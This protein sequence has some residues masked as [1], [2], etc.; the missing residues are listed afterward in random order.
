MDFCL[1]IADAAHKHGAHYAT[2]AGSGRAGHEGGKKNIIKRKTNCLGSAFWLMSND[3]KRSCWKQTR[4]FVSQH[5]TAP[6]TASCCSPRGP[7]QAENVNKN[8]FIP[9]LHKIHSKRAYESS[10]VK[11]LYFLSEKRKVTR[12]KKKQ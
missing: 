6:S 3:D 7:A 12:K 11:H 1:D 4:L 10:G 9:F 5:Q 8:P 2:K